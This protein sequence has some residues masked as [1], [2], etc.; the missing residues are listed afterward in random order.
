MT[1]IAGRIL[2]LALSA[3]TALFAGAAWANEYDSVFERLL[4][5]PSDPALNIRYAELAE[6]NGE[7]RKALGAYERVLGEDPTNAHARREYNRVKRL[8]QPTVTQVTVDLGVR[9]ETNPRQLPDIPARKGDVGFDGGIQLF[10]ERTAFG[11]R[12]RTQALAR[13]DLQG[14][15]SD[16]NDG[17]L[18]AWTGPVFNLGTKT[19][20]HIAPGTEIAFLDGDHLYTD[21]QGRATFERVMGGA[22]QTLSA[23]IAYRDSNSFDAASGWIYEI[24]A[25][26]SKYQVVLPGDAF[27]LLPR[28][29]Y[30]EPTGTGDGR[31]FSRPL[32]LGDFFEVGNRV[33]YFVPAFNNAIFLG[34]GFGAY[35][36]DYDTTV[37]FG[38]KTREDWFLEPTAHLIIP[39]V[40][41]R[42]GDLRFDYRYQKNDSNDPTQDFENHV[43]GA[44]TVKRF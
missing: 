32:F 41:G 6:A 27:Y 16:L 39:N 2:G 15:I 13:T 22:T 29:R 4:F 11:H 5:D 1:R 19:R 36:R 43:I 7:M 17:W 34:G 37:A 35:Y 38:T 28:L 40:L 21:A 12:W 18:S 8:L 33:E 25:R 26:L 3:A 20:L 44:R 14:D 24:N 23:L 30:N 9:Y 42:N 10:D 31:V